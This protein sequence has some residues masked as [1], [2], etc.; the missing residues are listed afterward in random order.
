MRTTK[1]QSD[2]VCFMG[3]QGPKA[4][5]CRQQRLIRLGGCPGCFESLLGGHTGHFVAFVMLIY[6]DFEGTGNYKYVVS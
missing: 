3:S 6:F 5:S 1:T 2:A 4:S